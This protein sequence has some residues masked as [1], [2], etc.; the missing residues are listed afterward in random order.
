MALFIVVGLTLDG[1]ASKVLLVY[2]ADSNLMSVVAM[3]R[4]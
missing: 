2:C 1:I 3:G 4:D